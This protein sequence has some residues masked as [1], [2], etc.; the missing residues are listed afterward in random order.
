MKNILSIAFIIISFYSCKAQTIYPLGTQPEEIQGDDYYIK[1]TQNVYDSIEGIWLWEVGTSSF[2][3]TLEGFEMVSLSEESTQ[4]RDVVFGKY[5]YIVNG[6]TIAEVNNIP[7]I[8]SS[9]PKVAISYKSATVFRIQ[10]TDILSEKYK[11]GEF[12]LNDNGTATI[13]LEDPIGT[14]GLYFPD[15][16]PTGLDFQLPINIILTKVE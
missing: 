8:Q 2:E 5:K 6:N 10:I 3:L 9:F 11:I 15:N 4:Y 7:N 16:P 1:D 13:S 12:V 14:N